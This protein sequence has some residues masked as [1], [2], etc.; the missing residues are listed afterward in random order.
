[1]VLNVV[2]RDCGL[3]LGIKNFRLQTLLFAQAAALRA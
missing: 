1:V 3:L 2:L